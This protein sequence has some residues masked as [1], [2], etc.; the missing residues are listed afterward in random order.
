MTKIAYV[1][2]THSC[3]ILT[4]DLSNHLA[5]HTKISLGSTT[6]SSRSSLLN[7][8]QLRQDKSECSMFNEANHLTFDHFISAVTWNEITDDFDAQ[9]AYDNFEEIYLKHYNEAYPLKSKRT[10]RKNERQ[11]P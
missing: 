5:T 11:N 6:S 9:T 2:S 3:N 1:D 10:R 4:H 7:T 8:V